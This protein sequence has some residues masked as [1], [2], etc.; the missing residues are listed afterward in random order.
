MAQKFSSTAPKRIYPSGLRFRVVRWSL[1]ADE[2]HLMYTILLYARRVKHISERACH[3]VAT[4]AKSPAD[5][6]GAQPF[7]SFEMP[8]SRP[9]MRRQW[10]R[11]RARCGDC[12][13][14]GGN[15]ESEH[16]CE[17]RTAPTPRRPFLPQSIYLVVDVWLRM[18][19]ACDSRLSLSEFSPRF[20]FALRS[21]TSPRTISPLQ[22]NSNDIPG[23][24]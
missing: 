14:G 1:F 2:R 5:F 8:K 12:A 13:E 4:S 7:P 24:M 17:Y 23:E 15:V 21:R 11:S 9:R 6:A 22:Y 19:T 10:D 3:Q 18:S 16:E 20:S